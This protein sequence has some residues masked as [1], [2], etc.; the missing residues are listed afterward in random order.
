MWL[1]RILQFLRSRRMRTAG[2]VAVIAALALEVL[3]YFGVP[4]LLGHV[5]RV[6][7]AAAIHR[8]ASVGRIRFNLYTL[9]LER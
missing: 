5:L 4:I 2:K 7:V 8:P 9:R 6:Q 3:A 1:T